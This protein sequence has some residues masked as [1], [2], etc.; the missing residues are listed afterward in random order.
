MKRL[1]LLLLLQ[2][3][4]MLVPPLVHTQNINMDPVPNNS[5]NPRNNFISTGIPNDLV[6]LQ[7]LLK[8]LKDIENLEITTFEGGAI[9]KGELL[10]PED[11]KRVSTVADSFSNVFNLCSLHGEAL[12]TAAI[13]IREAMVSIGIHGL[14]M[15]VL[16][17]NLFLTGRPASMDDVKRV[18]RICEALGLSFIDGTREQITDPR[19]LIFE[20]NFT[21]INKQAFREIGIDWPSSIAL[22]DPSGFRLSRLSPEKSL[23]MMISVA[24]LTGKAR[25]LS[26]PRLVCRS[27]E[28]ASFLA[29]GEIAIPRKDKDGQIAV[30]WKRYGIILEINPR[31]DSDGLIHARITSEVSMV[32]HSNSIEG[33]PGILTRKI[34]TYLSL[35]S[36]QT[37]VLSGLINNEDA[38]NI[39]KIPLLG[40]IPVL[41]E[42]FKSR[43]FKKRETELLVFLTPRIVDPDHL[44]PDISD[45]QK[46]GL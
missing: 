12:E 17:K 35:A 45:N 31:L 23:E 9:L 14:D 22:S 4:L 15:K 20:I 5:G 25:I 41:G 13:Y 2:S 33:I 40:D 7:K 21:E 8:S 19:M 29:G 44:L 11:L 32:D 30:T 27:G 43:S 42:L 6:G 34:S 1:F 39:T 38:E 3:S 10:T 24:A 28:S 37:A 36:G 46:V 16:G 18:E 26:S